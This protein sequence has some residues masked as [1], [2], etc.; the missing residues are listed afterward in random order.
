MENTATKMRII[1]GDCTFALKGNGFHYL[2][3][4]TRGGLESL[5]KY[6]KEW[7]YRETLP[8]FWRALTDNDRGSGFG[9]RSSM[10]LGAGMYPKVKDVQVRVDQKEIKRPIA[11]INNRYSNHE[12][13]QSAEIIFT[14]AIHTVPETTVNVSYIVQKN[15]EMKITVTYYG[16]KGLPD[17]PLLG[18]RF[19][20]PTPAKYFEY[21]GLYGETY[22]DR[23]AGGK[24]GVYRV[25]GLPVTP[26]LVPQDC[27]VHMKTK[28]LEITRDA[29]LNNA[30]KKREE[31]SLRFEQVTGDFAFS[32]LPYKAEELE[33]ATHIEELPPARR[34]VLV[35][36]GKVRGVGG[37]NS[38]GADVEEAYRIS[39]EKN[40]EFSFIVK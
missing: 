17:L 28:W 36:L 32:A 18:L 5:N 4:Y 10:W 2:F 26:Y 21:E 16:Q 19:I 22:P 35:I 27:G 13:A 3:S 30:D 9:Q 14:L 31:F 12:Y 15:G 6:G 34:T 37:I 20:M 24:E 38:W 11:P 29:T 7:L 39:A 23:M 1:Y 8:T 33:N 40:H 25:E